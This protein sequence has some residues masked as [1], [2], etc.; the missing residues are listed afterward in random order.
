MGRQG[1]HQVTQRIFLDPALRE[2]CSTDRQRECFDAVIEHGSIPNAERALKL[3]EGVIYRMMD[4]VRSRAAAKGYAPGHFEQGVA[5]GYRM[6]KVTVHRN[7]MGEIEQTWER[8]HPEDQ[9]KEAL[10]REFIEDLAER[11]DLTS[12]LVAPPAVCDDDLLACYPMGDPHL[13]MIA[14]AEESGED[15][16]LETAQ[17]DLLTAFDRLVASAPPARHAL[18]AEL[19]DFFHSDNEQNRTAR[20]GNSL[21]AD[22]WARVQRA[23][24]ETMVACVEKVAAKHHFVTVRIVRGNHDTH[25]SYALSLALSMYFRNQDRITVVVDANAHWYFEFGKVLIGLTHGDTSKAADMPGIMAS[26]RAEAWGRTL[27]RYWYHGHI[28]N[29]KVSEGYGAL[30]ESF[31]TLAGKDAWH[32]AE[33]YRSGQDM[34]MIVHDREYGEI[35]RTR[36]DIRLIRAARLKAAA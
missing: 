6:G 29:K 16:N 25:G 35:M 14:Y 24:L 31:R 19:G 7:K 21:D 15:F 2:H 22:R 12:P 9:A 3:S 30:V 27:Y 17:A 36:A 26:D 18:I 5:A 11:K 28:H 23:G 13:G 32:S 8:Q 10:I 34:T 33:G 20:S 1:C 4:K